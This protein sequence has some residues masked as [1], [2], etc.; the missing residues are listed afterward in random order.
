MLAYIAAG[1]A[2][3][4]CIADDVSWLDC[5]SAVPFRSGATRWLLDLVEPFFGPFLLRYRYVLKTEHGGGFAI[6]AVDTGHGDGSCPR[7]I[8]CG[9]QPRRGVQRVEVRRHNDHVLK[10]VLFEYLPASA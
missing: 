3:I 9:I 7:E 2:R 8:V 5:V 1:L 4:P 10:A 6:H